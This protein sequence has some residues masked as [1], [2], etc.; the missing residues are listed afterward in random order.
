[1]N[2]NRDIPAKEFCLLSKYAFSCKEEI[3]C[4]I[5][6]S[7]PEDKYL[8]EF[9][10]IV[11]I[12]ED[13]YTSNT[14]N[15]YE[16][17]LKHYK[18]NI[19]IIDTEEDMLNSNRT[20]YEDFI[21]TNSKEHRKVSHKPIS[22]L[23]KLENYK[24]LNTNTN[25]QSNSNINSANK[26]KTNNIYVNKSN[27]NNIC[28]KDDHDDSFKSY[29]SNSSFNSN[30][31]SSNFLNNN[32]ISNTSNNNNIVNTSS[33]N[34]INKPYIKKKTMNVASSFSNK[35]LIKL[36]ESV[37]NNIGNAGNR[38]NAGTGNKHPNNNHLSFNSTNTPFSS[39]KYK[40]Y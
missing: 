37:L 4:I 23:M 35:K 10:E 31:N 34:I 28:I 24:N 22:R 9:V 16:N 20:N 21:N 3:E 18:N 1:M 5:M 2:N 12:Y 17:D 8:C 36:T 40:Y 7:L 26:N 13:D 15:N 25:N 32:N 19:K 27:T 11:I 6:L 33:T 30:K 14:S 29:H 38:G 39:F